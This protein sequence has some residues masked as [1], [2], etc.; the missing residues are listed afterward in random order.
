[1]QAEAR[2][3]DEDS[4]KSNFLTTSRVGVHRPK[5]NTESDRCISVDIIVENSTT[6]WSEFTCIIQI[7]NAVLYKGHFLTGRCLFVMLQSLSFANKNYLIHI[8]AI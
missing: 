2:L 8:L 7:H 6:C 1:M 5:K 4:N 3:A